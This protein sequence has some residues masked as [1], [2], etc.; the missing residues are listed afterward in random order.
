MPVMRTLVAFLVGIPVIVLVQ[1]W[2]VWM[3]SPD[4]MQETFEPVIKWFNP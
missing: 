4:Q 2:M 1:M 3:I